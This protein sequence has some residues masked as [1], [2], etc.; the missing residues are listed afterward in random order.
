MEIVIKIKIQTK[1]KS[2]IIMTR[3]RSTLKSTRTISSRI[4]SK[5]RKAPVKKVIAK[6]A[7]T[8]R[9]KAKPVGKAAVKKQPVAP[10]KTAMTRE[11]RAGAK[12]LDLC[13]VLDCTGSMGSWIKRSK[14][15]LSQIIDHVKLSNKGL[16]VRVGFVAYRDV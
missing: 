4:A 15:T 12:T 3:T 2:S 14:E 6:V 9:S 8:K 10:K 16:T 1:Q 13:L 7:A 11:D 5:A